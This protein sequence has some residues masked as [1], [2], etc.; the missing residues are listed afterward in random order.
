[1]TEWLADVTLAHLRD[2]ADWPDLGLRYE[3]TGRVGRGGMGVVYAAHDRTLNRDVA[4][5]VLDRPYHDTDAVARL[6]DE[7]KI[8]A[9]LEHPGIVPVHDAGQLEDGRVFYVM[10]LVRGSR[11]DQLLEQAASI[12]ERLA[13]F[14]RICDAVS[15]AHAQGIVHRDLKPENVMVGPFGEV[16]VMDWGVAKVLGATGDPSRVVLGTA[17][18]MSPEQAK[19][20]DDRVDQRTDVFALGALLEAMM[21][22]PI[23][24]RVLAIAHRASAPQPDL[25]YASVEELARD[26]ARYRDGE[27]VSAYQESVFERA[28]RVY[29]RYQLPILLVLAYMLMRTLLLLWRGV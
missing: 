1:V 27:T 4:I 21:P 26:V 7:A 20:E 25:R 11:L 3:V 5:K 17:G 28:A 23:P 22:R 19:G 13:M 2:V 10:K 14:G 16:L 29:T 6:Q 18:F 24:K 8:L 12:G 9:R 15:F